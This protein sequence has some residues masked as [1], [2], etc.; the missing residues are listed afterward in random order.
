MSKIQKWMLSLGIVLIFIF[1]VWMGSHFV[2]AP[3]LI[4]TVEAQGI[5]V[6][7]Q[8]PDQALA[9]VFTVSQD[10]SVFYWWRVQNNGLGKVTTFNSNDGQVKVQDFRL[11]TE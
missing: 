3:I 7:L 10:G 4:P 2:A 1:G 9:A 5:Q 11:G 8:H 6:N